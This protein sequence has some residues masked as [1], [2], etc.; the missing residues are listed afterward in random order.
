MRL[1]MLIKNDANVINQRAKETEKKEALRRCIFIFFIIL[2]ISSIKFA[3]NAQ[4]TDDKADSNLKSSARVNPITRAMELTIP[5]ANYPGRAGNSIPIAL[6]YS[7]KVWDMERFRTRSETTHIVNDDY[8]VRITTDVHA[9]YSKKAV[10]GWTSSLRPP[11]ITDEGSDLYDALNFG[12]RVEFGLDE[13]T[14]AYTQLS[15]VK[16]VRIEM[17]DG[18]SHELRKDDIIY[19]CWLS[20]QCS[21]STDGT[22]LSVDGSRMRLERGEV[23]PN[24]EKRDVLYMPDGSRYVF[25][26][27]S[28]PSNNHLTAEKYID[29]HGNTTLYNHSTQ[30]WTDTLGRQIKDPLPNVLA[31]GPVPFGTQNYF[32][33]GIDGENLTYQVVWTGLGDA[34]ER[35]AS[36]NPIYTLKHHG[37]DTCSTILMDPVPGPSLFSNQP[38]DPDTWPDPNGPL[39]HSYIRNTRVCNDYWG[40]GWGEFAPSVMSELVLPSGRKYKFEYNEYGEITKITY[41]TG[42][43]ERFEYEI[44]GTTGFTALE[45]YSQGNRGVKK[46]FVSSDGV[47]EAQTWTYEDGRSIAPDGSKQE[48]DVYGMPYSSFGF[49]NPLS[50]MPVE[51]RSYDTAGQLTSRVLTEWTITSG[52]SYSPGGVVPLA[53]RDPRKR[54]TVSIKIEN[55]LALVSMNEIVYDTAGNSNPAYFSSLNPKQARTYNNVVVSAS[56]AAS[57]NMTTAVGWFSAESPA[58]VTEMD[59]LYDSNYKA[60]NICGLVTEARVLNPSNP[61]DVLTK[62]QF[63]YDES[64]YFDNSYTTTSWETPNTNIRGNVT[65]AKTWNKDTNTWIESHTMFDNFGNPRKVWDTTGD[66]SRFVETEYD[67]VYKYAYPTKTKAPAPDPTGVHGTTQGAEISIVYDFNTGLLLSVTDANGQTATT[68]YD[69][70]LRPIRINPPTGGS[71][72]ETI[73]NDDPNDLWVKSRRQIDENNWAESTTFYDK[74]GR[75]FKTRT[76]DLQGDVMSQVKFDS[77]GRVEKASNPYRVDANGNP[78][79]TVYWSKPRYDERNRVVETFAPAPEGQTGASLGTVQFGISNLPNL[80]GTYAVAIDASGRKSRAITG[81]YGLMRVDEATGKDGTIDQDLGTL[82]SPTQP[83]YY[84]Y[85]FKGEMTKITQ[86]GQNRHF[87]YDSLGR[88]IRVRQPEQIANPHLATSGNPENNQWTASYSYD[89]LGHVVRFTDAKG[90]NIINEYDKTGRPT[91]RCYTKPDIQTYDTQ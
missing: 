22:Y 35:N 29:V 17:P 78:T 13:P 42:A 58:V 88:L 61:T 9:I 45:V 15:K 77:F 2:S 74:L 63:I 85:N 53:S 82:A 19:E 38:G 66:P 24:S 43:Y 28:S 14:P 60:R 56:T 34:I 67:P 50:S 75:L 79:E 86:G 65:T 68:E 48:I 5:L 7:S 21:D 25:P 55:N 37:R 83:T 90:L 80:I 87:M 44:V 30:E 89:V 20:P 32:V 33:K 81:I 10:S 39:N 26:V 49:D 71:V 73:Y 1:I 47:T 52:E 27:F 51:E 40:G 46:R 31:G 69:D 59:Y 16:R 72:S 3:Q 91:S 57:A 36:G 18:S 8:L 54:K 6:R 76:K 84:S 4:S 11:V 64:A 41:P 23:Q 12:F 70:F 62:S